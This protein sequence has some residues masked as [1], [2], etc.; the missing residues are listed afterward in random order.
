[1]LI[2]A[3]GRGTRLRS[4]FRSGPKSMAPVGKRPFLEYLLKWLRNAG[5]R[6][7]ILCV[8]YKKAEI[9]SWLGDGQN[10]GLRVKYSEEKSL[11]GTGGALKNAEKL[12]SSSL[13]LVVNGDSFLDVDLGAMFRFHRQRRAPATIALARVPD[14]TRYGTVTLDRSRHITSFQEKE[15]KSPHKIDRTSHRAF[16]LI[17]G[18]VYLLEKRVLVN[19]P[20]RRVVSLEKDIFPA[21][22][23]SRLYGF[24]SRG[25]FID[26]GIPADFA[27]AQTELPERFRA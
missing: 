26:I 10:W 20:P 15:K 25:Y 9:Q 2:L 16:Q 22:T 11:L 27:R 6:D 1:V 8:G 7:V 17:N 23:G 5:L 3:G 18:G 13:C 21:M 19:I 14:S 24:P 4:A 12:V